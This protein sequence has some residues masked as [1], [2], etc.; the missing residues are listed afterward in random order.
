MRRLLLVLVPL[1]CLAL[2]GCQEKTDTP[3]LSTQVNAAKQ[4][5]GANVPAAPVGKT[6]A[7]Q[8]KSGE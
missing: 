7:K 4:Q 6:N 5:P 1:A 3:D 8:A 2:F